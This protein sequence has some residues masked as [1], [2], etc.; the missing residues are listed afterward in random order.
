MLT[1][2]LQVDAPLGQVT[3]VKEAIEMDL[4]KYG[5]VRVVSVTEIAPKQMRMI[6][7]EVHHG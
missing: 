2:T 3:G 1:I 5:D 4:E 6:L 7:Q